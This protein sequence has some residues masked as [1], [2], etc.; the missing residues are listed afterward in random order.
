M[1]N[2]KIL[3]YSSVKDLSSFKTSGFYANDIKALSSIGYNV[4][5]TNKIFPFF[6]FWRYDVS[7]LYFYKKSFFPALISKVFNKYIFFTGGI[8]ELSLSVSLSKYQLFRQK[9]FFKFCYLLSSKCNIVS[10]SD[11]SN[12][13]DLL[14]QKPAFNTCKL[15]LFPHCVDVK[16]INKIEFKAKQNVLVTIC[17]MGSIENVKRKGLDRCMFFLKELVKKDL[18]YKLFIIGSFGEGTHFL[19]KIISD[20]NLQEFV[21]FT[22][23][24]SEIEKIDYLTKSKYY[25]QLSTYEGFGLAVI[26]AMINGCYIIHSNVGG[27][28]DTIVDNVLIIENFDSYLDIANSFID[29]DINYS[30]KEQLIIKNQKNV[31]EKYSIFSRSNYFKNNILS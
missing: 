21:I 8:D 15:S 24:I 29:S 12:T 16:N 28:K 5:V 3:F 7:F 6:L 4:Q 1:G 26:E 9:I 18:G 14:S 13:L 23:E 20:L 17:W 22:G 10:N 31:F 25:L 11:L 19:K 2:S 27:L 30:N